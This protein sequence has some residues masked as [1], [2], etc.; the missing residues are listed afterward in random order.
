MARYLSFDVNVVSTGWDFFGDPPVD[1]WHALID[2]ADPGSVG[3]IGNFYRFRHA[4]DKGFALNPDTVPKRIRWQSARKATPDILPW[5][6]VSA[7]FR[8]VV[9]RFEPGIHQFIPV[10]V[11]RDRKGE[12][13]E[14]YFWF[15][16]CKLL[17]SVNREKTTY[18]WNASSRISPDHGYW[19]DGQFDKVTGEWERVPDAR[20]V[21]GSTKIAGHHLWCDP[22]ILSF[23]ERLCSEEFAAAAVREGI[24]G[25]V[26]SHREEG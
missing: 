9:E 17:D 22:H 20:M 15:S 18:L 19:T 21:F 16:V 12:R 25:L 3:P 13:I 14:E 6:A 2:Y 11:W 8:D 23:G 24:T 1:Q 5:F 10:E 4:K 26:C 7:K